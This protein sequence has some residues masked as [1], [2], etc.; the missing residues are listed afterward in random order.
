MCIQKLQIDLP[1]NFELKNSI[2]SDEDLIKITMIYILLSN[3]KWP[4]FNPNLI[5]RKI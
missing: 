2:G 5:P 3:L 1:T 4:P